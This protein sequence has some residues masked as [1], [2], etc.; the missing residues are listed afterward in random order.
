M[1]SDPR[2]RLGWFIILGTLPIGLLG[3][4]LQH[5]IETAFRDLRILAATLI[6]F[7]L[8]L[9]IADRI[10]SNRL[11]LD[12]LTTRDASAMGFAQA[13]ALVPGVSRFGGHLRPRSDHRS[14]C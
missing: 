7:G 12:R 2:A 6:G 5:P 3:L 10:A 8:I 1:R 9:G 14:D 4:T 11:P 13:L